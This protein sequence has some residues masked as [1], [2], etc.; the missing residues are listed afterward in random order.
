VIATGEVSLFAGS[1]SPSL[2]GRIGLTNEIGTAALFYGPLGITN[3]GTNLY[4][5]DS[6]NNEI[7][8]VVIATAAVTLLGGSP[9]GAS[10]SVN[11]TGPA[12]RFNG[13]SGITINGTN[14][15]VSDG[16]QIRQIQ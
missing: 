2:A 4:V 15:Y 1:P 9:T 14:L 7:R 3:Y 6:Q 8:Q 11:G 13:P 10:G 5:A 12:T 16:N